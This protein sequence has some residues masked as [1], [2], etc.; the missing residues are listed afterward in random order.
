MQRI[1]YVHGSTRP[2]GA[3]ESLRDIVYGLE[4]ARF[5]P[6]VACSKPPAWHGNTN[7]VETALIRMPMARKGKSFP[8]IPFAISALRSLIRNRDV[9]LLH[10]NSLWDVPYAIWAIKPFKIPV[11][12]HVRTEID[13]EKAR[14]YYL[15]KADVVISTSRAAESILTEF[16]SLK[17]RVFY[18]P[19]GVDLRR[20]DPAISGDA[21]RN[22]YGFEL[23]SIVFGAVGRIDHLKGLDLLIAAFSRVAET[24]ERARLLIVGEAKGKGSS[25]KDDLLRMIA[26][27]GLQ[28]R[29]V[30]T[31]HQ[32]DPIPYYAAIDILV[33]PSRTEGFGRVVV[34]AMAMGKPIITSDAGALPEIVWN[35]HT[36]YVVPLKDNDALVQRMIE[37]GASEMVRKT[38]GN[39]GRGL[40]EARFDLDTAVSRL[41]SIYDVL[42][43][44]GKGD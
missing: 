24:S 32:E 30:M 3:W 19:N 34:E 27:R 22:R 42:L 25:F 9:S 26:E 39:A 40:V 11:V 2:G 31:G 29:I 33:M 16:G 41:Q 21:V 12:A 7:G 28:D 37:L 15:D 23:D 38:M 20:F 8:R 5:E 6:V 10:A 35:G 18:M 4:R 1:L 36:G 14:K 43:R 17:G 13:S 44:T